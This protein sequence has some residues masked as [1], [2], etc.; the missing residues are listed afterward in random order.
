MKDA[1]GKLVP[2]YD[3]DNIT[4]FARL[5]TG[6]SKQPTRANIEADA[7]TGTANLIDPLFMKVQYRDRFPKAALDNPN[8][9]TN[10]KPLP[11]PPHTHTHTHSQ[12][13][14]ARQGAAG[15]T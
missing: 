8:P 14:V 13:H 10:T 2:T 7:G 3:N 6:Y 15:Q 9:N 1:D 11:Y 4:P 12:H 5:W